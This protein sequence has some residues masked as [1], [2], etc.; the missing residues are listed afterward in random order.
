MLVTDPTALAG[1]TPRLLD[2]GVW[3]HVML[4]DAA[5]LTTAFL[6]AIE[7]AAHER[8]LYAS[9]ASVWEFA[10]QSELG[11]IVIDDLATLIANQERPPGVSILPITTA[12]IVEAHYLPPFTP[13][14]DPSA[15]FIAA[16]ARDTGVS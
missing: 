11:T 4:G 3:G 5:T 12:T 10:R 2:T 8:R 15:R 7:A 16:A 9:A 13:G 14:R 1:P 6:A